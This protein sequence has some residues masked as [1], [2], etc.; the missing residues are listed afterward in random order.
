MVINHK[1]DGIILQV[2]VASIYVSIHG[3]YIRRFVF[4]VA[5]FCVRQNLA[6]NGGGWKVDFILFKRGKR[7]N[8]QGEAAVPMPTKPVQPMDSGSLTGSLLRH[9]FS[10]Y[11]DYIGEDLGLDG[12]KAAKGDRYLIEASVDLWGRMIQQQQLSRGQN[13]R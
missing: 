10:G 11:V 3:V 9:L 1:L 2:E 8:F 5:T 6:Q 13:K 4:F 12:M 7:E